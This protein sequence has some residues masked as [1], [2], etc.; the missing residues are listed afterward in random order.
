MDLF[1]S[2]RRNT[3][4]SLAALINEKFIQKGVNTFF[5]RENIHNEDFWEKIKKGIDQSPNFLMI[6]TPGYFICRENEEDYV[7]KEILYAIQNNKKLLAISSSDYNPNE[8]DWNL[9]IEE[10]RNLKTFDYKPWPKDGNDEIISVFLNSY[11]RNMKSHTGGRFSLKK[12]VVN[13]SWYSSHEMDDEDYLWIKT[14]HIVC[15]SLDWDMLEKAIMSEGLFP[16]RDDLNLLCYKAYDIDT[17]RKKYNL[18]PRGNGEQPLNKRIKNVYGVT[19]RGLI[20]EAN[21]TFGEGHFV[22]DEFDTENYV[23]VIEELLIKNQLNGF[24]IIDLTLIIKDLPEPEKMV[25]ELTKYLNPE[26]GIIYI[27]EL[28]DDY[29]DAYPDDKNLVKKLKE[30]LELDDGAGNRHTGKK[31]YTFLMRAGAEKVYMADKIITTA[32]HKPGF[33]LKMFQN[34][35]SYLKPELRALSEDTEENKSNPNYDKYR[36]AYSWLN[37]NYDDIESMFCSLDFYFRAGYVV[38]YGVFRTDPE[39]D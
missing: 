3:G 33:R 26:G 39:L 32:N 1:I 17:Y 7:R 31:I 36:N 10:I 34:Y 4:G 13:N 25:R 9:Q 37:D 23:H 8:I 2:Y 11:I 24:D 5:D 15:R 14:D 6:L 28:D 30:I 29:I 35:F 20:E 38:G 22:S 21:A 12:E 16:D 19:Y 18:R 27:R